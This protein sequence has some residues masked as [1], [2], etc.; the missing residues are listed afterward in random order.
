[1]GPPARLKET[2]LLQDYFANNLQC[3]SK[4][5]LLLPVLSLKLM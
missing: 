3:Q 5:L 1:M 2:G 4:L